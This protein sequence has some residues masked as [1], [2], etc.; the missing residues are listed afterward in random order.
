MNSLGGSP[1]NRLP[2]SYLLLSLIGI[3]I[4]SDFSLFWMPNSTN[5]PLKLIYLT[6]HASEGL[7]NFSWHPQVSDNVIFSLDIVAWFTARLEVRWESVLS[8]KH[9]I[10]WSLS[11]WGLDCGAVNQEK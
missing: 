8:P 7:G 2:S 1:Y 3:P 9:D 11:S 4:P 6:E 5:L 10:G